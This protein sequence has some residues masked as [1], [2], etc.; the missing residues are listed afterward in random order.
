VDTSTFTIGDFKRA[1]LCLADE[2]QDGKTLDLDTVES[3]S[4]AIQSHVGVRDF[5]M[6]VILID[7]FESVTLAVDFYTDLLSLV[8]TQYQ[9]PL[10]T[11]LSVLWYGADEMD[12]SAF[13]LSEALS[14]NSDYALAK[15]IA[16]VTQAGWPAE[17]V[18]EMF[19]TLHPKVRAWAEE[20]ADELVMG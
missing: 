18:Q 3:V 4:W 5:A 8:G 9:A 1:L 20:S 13:H 11:I 16:K 6:G 15:L 19:T 17:A 14:L 12:K 7:K 10:H 2:W